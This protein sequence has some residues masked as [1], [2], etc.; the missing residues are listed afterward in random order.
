[1][2]ESFF[3][4]PANS[5]RVVREVLRE[6]RWEMLPHPSYSSDLA[7]SDL[8]L[9]PKLNDSIKGTRFT[10]IAEAKQTG[11]TWF[12]TKPDNFFRRGLETWKHRLMECF[13][14]EGNYIEK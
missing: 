8:F 4:A 1:M 12:D 3:N 7:P 14:V 13:E 11:N 10:S 5:S 6:F 9:F 2:A